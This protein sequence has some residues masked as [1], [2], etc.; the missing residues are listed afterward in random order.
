MIS[1][2]RQASDRC[3]VDSSIFKFGQQLPK[4][5]DESNLLYIW[6]STGEPQREV[7]GGYIVRGIEERCLGKSHGF[8]AEDQMRLA[9]IFA[10]SCNQCAGFALRCE[11]SPRQAMEDILRS[12][13]QRKKLV[14][15]NTVMDVGRKHLG[16]SDQG[17]VHETRDCLVIHD[18]FLQSFGMALRFPCRLPRLSRCE[19]IESFDPPKTA[20]MFHVVKLSALERRQASMIWYFLDRTCQGIST[21][22]VDFGPKP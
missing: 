7:G 16:Y 15:L 13:R 22:I 18:L 5:F 19:H 9:K 17:C 6:A 11:Q 10:A 2:H 8:E 3:Q 20:R 4:D 12:G 14:Q 1:K 21:S